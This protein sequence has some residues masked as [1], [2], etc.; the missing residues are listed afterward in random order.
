[1]AKDK[2][3][4]E[5]ELVDMNSDFLHLSIDG[6]N[7]HIRWTACSPKLARATMEE[8]GF[9]V[10]APSGY[11]IH[12]PLVDE[13]LAIDPLLKQAKAAETASTEPIPSSV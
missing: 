8:R 9:I 3:F 5:I 4:H 13:D 6:R 2:K 11:G 10:I 1:M 7:Y 12:W